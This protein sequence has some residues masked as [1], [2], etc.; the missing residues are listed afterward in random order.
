MHSY[1]VKSK[2]TN[3]YQALNSELWLPHRITK[4]WQIYTMLILSF[5]THGIFH[6]YS[7]KSFEIWYVGGENQAVCGGCSVEMKLS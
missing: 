1:A 4:A 5:Y 6:A 2:S 7:L 3:F